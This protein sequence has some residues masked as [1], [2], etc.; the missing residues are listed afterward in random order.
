M[1]CLK[2]GTTN[3]ATAS[4][5][6]NCGAPLEEQ[7][8]FAPIP[9]SPFN[10]LPV[11][12][13]S[14]SMPTVVQ[15][16]GDIVAFTPLSQIS[17]A[18]ESL[19][20][21]DPALAT[22]PPA[23]FEH[24][25]DYPTETQ[26]PAAPALPT[27]VST[28]A[29]APQQF[30]QNGPVAPAGSPISSQIA[31][32]AFPQDA[33]QGWNEGTSYATPFS[34]PPTA[35]TP[36][37]AYPVSPENVLAAI[38][39]RSTLRFPSGPAAGANTFVQ[40]L[41]RWVF[42]SGIAVVVLLLATLIF[43]NADWASGAMAAGLVAIILALLLLI[44]AGVRVALGMLAETNPHRR[45]QVIGTALPVLLLFL[46]SGIGMTQQTS[47]HAMQARYLEGQQNWS[48]SISEYQLAGETAPA[49]EN[50]ARVYNEWG[51]ALSHQQQYSS[52]VEK[53]TTVLNR[54]TGVP[55]Q[56]G[57][58]RNDMVATYLAWADYAS[59]HQNYASATASYNTLLTLSYCNASCQALA[60]P[61]D[62]TAYDNL[63]EQ[64][65][66]AQ[67]F[68][69]AVNAFATLTTRF[70]NS[71]EAKQPQTH[72]DYAKALLGLG[73]QQLHSSACTSAVPTYE[74]LARSFADTSQGQ[75]AATALQQPVPVTGRFTT[76][77]PGPPFHP[78][79]SLVQGLFVGIQQF[80]FPPLLKANLTVPINSDGTFTFPSVPQGTYELVWS[81]DGTLHFYYASNG[82][83]V[84]YTAH[85]GPLCPY[86]YG[87]I[88]QTIPTTTT[89]GQ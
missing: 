89:A 22:T 1:L 57:R 6:A 11:P 80:Q 7:P 28:P 2:C 41:P 29:P 3:P 45:S 51:E 69:L 21:P 10:G 16:G 75:Q 83:Q 47:L 9:H 25:A 53:F 42:F 30:V 19:A 88:N 37:H 60:L 36:Q 82:Q 74:Q 66:G 44:A 70:A 67:Q 17:P 55:D 68:A 46:F 39:A 52:A 54:Y 56:L 5:C 87:A 50:L 35:H 24:L 63:A 40:P 81:S 18:R 27:Q 43:L 14:G 72:G 65:L 64:Q 86:N 79:V 26:V 85:V 48:A 73:Q 59:Q 31:G 8:W 76:T 78:T 4:S 34:T 61:K 84:L 62:A 32:P 33:Y 58:A 38:R 77:I 12:Q 71:P 49:S 13:P 15:P 23:T 20:P